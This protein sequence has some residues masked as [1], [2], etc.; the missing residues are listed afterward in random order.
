MNE[1]TLHLLVKKYINGTASAHDE[2][3]LLNW[4]RTKSEEETLWESSFPD[5]E[6][7]V[8]RRMLANILKNTR[9]VTVPFYRKWYAIA[10]TVLVVF[11]TGGFYISALPL[12]K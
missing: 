1:D 7:L 10:A 5:E 11:T 9:P 12:L 2:E 8:R 3:Q 4:Y 6:D